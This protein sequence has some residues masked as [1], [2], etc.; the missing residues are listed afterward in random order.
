M[1]LHVDTEYRALV[2]TLDLSKVAARFWPKVDKNG[3]LARPDLGP[4]WLFTGHIARNGYGRFGLGGRKGKAEG[5]HRVAWLLEHG[6]LP[7]IGLELDHRCRVHACVNPGHL[8][9]VTPSV[10]IT[11]SN[12]P[13][14]SV[15]RMFAR[16][17][18]SKGHAFG[19]DNDR[20]AKDGR[21]RCIPCERERA[22]RRRQAAA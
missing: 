21:R 2:A 3:P 20:F 4:C 16:T 13:L 5:A 9:A 22:A 14:R 6:E 8:E 19:G 18:C 7:P 10:N 11:R 17:H 1:S 12:A 15:E